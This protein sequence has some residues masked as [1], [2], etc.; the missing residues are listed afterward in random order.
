MI[1]TKKR[2]LSVVSI[3][4]AF[5]MMFMSCNMTTEAKGRPKP[6]KIYLKV[7]KTKVE[8]G[9][10]LYINV[11]TNTTSEGLKYKLSK[12]NI[13]K[14]DKKNWW[15]AKNVG[16]TTITFYL[17]HK[18]R[19]KKSVTITVTEKMPGDM[20]ILSCTKTLKSNNRAGH[21]S[22]KIYPLFT[23]DRDKNNIVWS[24]SNSSIVKIKKT[25][26][27]NKKDGCCKAYILGKK[28]GK[29][30]ITARSKYKNSEGK[31]LTMKCTI[32]VK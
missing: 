13:I 25:V 22:A 1:T 2:I 18:P 28:K 15:H 26:P 5:L 32:T 16:K 31:Y 30:T 14:Y 12:K 20:K 8:V 23:K 17:K 4:L 9:R 19:V 10:D 24:S 21:V 27:Y 7:D 6:T 11:S 29:A 3:L